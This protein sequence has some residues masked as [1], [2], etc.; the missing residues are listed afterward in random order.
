MSIKKSF[1]NKEQK[2][3]DDLWCCHQICRKPEKVL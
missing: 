2:D 1:C 3:S